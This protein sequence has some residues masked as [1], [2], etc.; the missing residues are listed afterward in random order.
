MQMLPRTLPENLDDLTVQVA[1]VR[2][3]PIQGGAVHPYIERRKRRREDPGFEIPYDHP[4][5]EEVLEDTL[6]T[7]V[8]Q[9][10]VLEVAKALA[11][12]S[13]A[14]AEALRRAMS[15]KRSEEA[16]DRHHRRF[17]EGAA[18]Q[19][20]ST[21]R[22]R[23]GS[24]SRSGASRASASR[25]R[26][27]PPSACSPTS[28]PGCGCIAP[29]SSSARCSTSSRWASTRPTRWST[30]RS[31][32]GC[33][34][35]APTPTAAA[36]SAG[37]SGSGA[38]WW[39]GSASA[40][41]RGCA[42]RRWRASSPPASAAGPTW[43][44]PTSPRAPGA[45]RDGLERLA[46][47]GALDE[48]PAGADEGAGGGRREA[49]WQV[50]V[51]P[52]A[53][54]A[55]E[56]AQLALPLEPPEPPAL[57]PLGGWE[58]MIADYRSTG[59]TLGE[60][61]LAMMRAGLDP[62]ILRSTDLAGVGDGSEVEVAGM[63]V[64]RQRPETAKGIVF[65]LLEDERGVVNLIVPPPVYER[66]RAV[67]RAAPL[68]RARGRLERR[69]GVVN[70]LVSEIVEP[71]TRRAPTNRTA[72]CR[73]VQHSAESAGP[74]RARGRR[75]ARRRPRRSQL[76]PAGAV[77]SHF[78]NVLRVTRASEPET[79]RFVRDR[80]PRKPSRAHLPRERK[81]PGA[82]EQSARGARQSA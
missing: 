79:I 8:Y 62:R 61:P 53:R 5:L 64:A 7:I 51:A 36:S 14:E 77:R 67:V 11:G 59:M 3:G 21:R 16:I 13:S 33:G 54:G 1:L 42:R 80:S 71:A 31:G 40:T 10:Q 45:G 58:A 49:L 25:R 22:R 12:F 24:G 19:R 28:R 32:A 65:M 23:S 43:G 78:S 46:W 26:T 66:H 41:S 55:G 50:G 63:V 44:S 6:G 82:D 60:H 56:G 30:R 27:R 81:H 73:K 37:W 4:L 17:L 69:E 29:R 57:A 75:A 52:N 47:A 34:S 35:S 39:C 76:G 15:R 2:P 38:A 20:A 18:E 68:A 72:E 74:P 48:I 9:E 70:I